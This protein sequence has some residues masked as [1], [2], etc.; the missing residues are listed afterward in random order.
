MN[1]I[2]RCTWVNQKNLR[3]ITYHDAEWG[4]PC[5]DDRMLFEMLILEG[6]QAGLSWECVLNKREAFRKAYDN[7]DVEKVATYDEKK[8][9]ELLANAGIIRNRLKINASINN[10]NVF[11]EIQ[12]EF[13][14]FDKYLWHFTNNEVIKE[15][16]TLRATSP[17]SDEISKDLIN[18]GMKYVGSTVIYS[19]LQAVG[20]INGHMEGCDWNKS[21][22]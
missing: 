22:E 20:V 19:F 1:I 18:R 3:Y 13:E 4:V 9:M 11:I 16:C 12:K 5:H 6:F 14:S 21:I 17:L 2:H 7:F 10:A 15:P 8:R